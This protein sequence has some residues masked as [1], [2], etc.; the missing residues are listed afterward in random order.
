M[1][2][3]RGESSDPH[4]TVAYPGGPPT[5]GGNPQSGL[6]VTQ[7]SAGLGVVSPPR[8]IPLNRPCALKT[9]S[10][11]GA[12]PTAAARLRAEAE[13]VAQLRHPNVVQIYSVREVAGVPFLELE[14]LPG[15]SLADP[16]VGGP[17]PAVEAAPGAPPP[18]PPAAARGRLGSPPACG[19]R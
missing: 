8:N 9:F 3:P 13:A 18:P 5:A 1:V 2:D 7:P 19:S 10:G 6:G 11:G 14:Y 16:P 4:R 15:G 17:R 12:G